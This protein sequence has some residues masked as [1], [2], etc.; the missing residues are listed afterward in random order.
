MTSPIIT[1][2]KRSRF[3]ILPGLARWICSRA[4]DTELFFRL[5]QFKAYYSTKEENRSALDTI[6]SSREEEQIF[7]RGEVISLLKKRL[8]KFPY[9]PKGQLTL[10]HFALNQRDLALAY[11]SSLAAA[12]LSPQ[13]KNYAEARFII[14]KCQLR[15]GDAAGALAVLEELKTNSSLD[16]TAIIEELGAAYLA[17]GMKPEAQEILQTISPDLQSMSCRAALEYLSRNPSG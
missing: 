13:G 12:K 10:A 6:V 5:W 14:S 4:L 7:Q 15:T 3:F 11:S 9:W 2:K 1:N 16:Q 17:L 8:R